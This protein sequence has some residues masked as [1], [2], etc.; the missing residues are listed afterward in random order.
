MYDVVN[1]KEVKEKKA[2]PSVLDYLKN[3]ATF[4]TNCFGQAT[5][6]MEMKL[7][8]GTWLDE[9]DPIILRA[10]LLLHSRKEYK[11]QMERTWQTNDIYSLHERNI[12]EKC[13]ERERGERGKRERGG[14]RIQ[15][16]N[17]YN[18]YRFKIGF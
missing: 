6:P 8:F 10:F 9:K 13:T 5:L 18:L 15:E 4:I 16:I 1:K 3:L 17:I 14:G 7:M 2:N 11:T 12:I